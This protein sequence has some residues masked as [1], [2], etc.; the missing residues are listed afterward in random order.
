MHYWCVYRILQKAKWSWAYFPACAGDYNHYFGYTIHQFSMITA[1]LDYSE[2][3]G[4]HYFS[5]YTQHGSLPVL[6]YGIVRGAK[7]YH[8]PGL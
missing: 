1:G 2:C 4:T 7:P 6:P 5:Y 3:A 8:L